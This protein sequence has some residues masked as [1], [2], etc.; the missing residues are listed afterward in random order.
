MPEEVNQ[1]VE[2]PIGDFDIVLAE[3]RKVYTSTQEEFD[4][5]FYAVLALLAWN[6]TFTPK[7]DLSLTFSTI[8]DEEYLSLLK[9][10]RKWAED[11]NASGQMFETYMT[12]VNLAYYLTVI[13]V[14]GSVINLREQPVEKRIEYLGKMPEQALNFYGMHNF[15]FNEIVRRSLIDSMTLK[16][17]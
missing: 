6:K 4:E 3:G 1:K 16:N 13:K 9:E 8:T 2:S 11:N 12:K 15:I 5:C 17:S 7:P 10:V 14:Q